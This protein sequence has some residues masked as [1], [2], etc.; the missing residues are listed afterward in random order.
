MVVVVVVVVVAEGGGGGRWRWRWGVAVGGGWAE[1]AG[2]ADE[3]LVY[4]FDYC[5]GCACYADMPV[6]YI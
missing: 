3:R 2:A 6:F 4:T 1:R 5:G